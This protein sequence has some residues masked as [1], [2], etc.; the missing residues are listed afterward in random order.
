MQG[1]M[2]T[3]QL[4]ISTLI[5]HAAQNHSDGEVVS[6]ASDGSITQ[7]TYAQIAKRSKQLANALQRLELR[8]GDR[9]GTLAWNTHRHLELYYGVSGS[10][11][12]NHTINP[13]L[14]FD[15]IV[16]IIGHARNRVI[17]FDLSFIDLVEKLAPKCKFV[18]HWIGLCSEGEADRIAG[19]DKASCYEAMLAAESDGFEW[20]QFDENTAASLCYT[21]GSTGDPKGVLYSHRSTVLHSYAAA[22]RD[23]FG[24][25]AND[26]VLPASSMYHANAWGVPYAATLTG[27]KL[28]LPGQLLDGANLC[29][30][31]D[32]EGVTVSCGVPTIW[33]GV[34][35]HLEKT[36]RTLRSLNR[37]VIGGSSC[38]PA[39]I[40]TLRERYRID[41]NQLWGMTETSPL[42]TVN[43]LKTKHA[44]LSASEKETMRAKQGRIVYGVQLKIVETPDASFHAMA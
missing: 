17:F 7:L 4:L 13:R 33:L 30:L 18:E 39:L 12:V 28:V 42:G 16:Y 25:S 10:G 5:D 6:R 21:S 43:H 2:Q 23:T 19:I 24:L 32:A 31:I 35:Q 8:C 22:M 9:V 3:P 41:V 37:I 26:V 14:F 29:E 38:P 27:S 34:L 20:P 40:T 15:Q 1:M 11:L 44:L 36:G